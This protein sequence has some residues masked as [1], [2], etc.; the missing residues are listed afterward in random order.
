MQVMHGHRYRIRLCVLFLALITLLSST[1]TAQW[2]NETRFG[3]NKVNYEEFGWKIYETEHFHVYFYQGE[4]HIA[5]AAAQMAEDA[6]GRLSDELEYHISDTV[7]IL[8]Y[9]SHNDF[10]QTNATWGLIGE[11]TLGFTE[12]FKNRIVLPFNGSYAEFRHVIH[13][14][15]VHAF[16]FDMFYRREGGLSA[17]GRLWWSPPLWFAEG[18]AEYYSTDWTTEKNMWVRGAVIDGYLSLDGYQ[19]YTSGYALLRWIGE[20]YGHK[21]IAAIMRRMAITNDPGGSF[22]AELGT[23]LEDIQIRWERH[24]KRFYWPEIER[25]ELV[26]EIA[27]PLTHHR[28]ERHFFNYSPAIA[29]QGDRIAFLSDREEYTSIYIMSAI[30]G[31][32]IRKVLTGEQSGHFE[33]MQFLRATIS[34]SPNGESIAFT[35]KDHSLDALYIVRAEDGAIEHRFRWP[36][37]NSLHGPD[38]SSDSLYIAFVGVKQG[39]SD[40]YTVNIATGELRQLTDDMHDETGPEWSP[41][42]TQIAFASDQRANASHPPDSLSIPVGKGRSIYVVDVETGRV[43]AVTSAAGNDLSPTWSPDGRYIAFSSDRNGIYNLYVSDLQEGSTDTSGAVAPDTPDDT[44]IPLTDVLNGVFLPHW[45]LDGRKIVFA[46]FNYG[47]YDIYTLREPLERLGEV[48]PLQ[49]AEYVRREREEQDA[50]STRYLQ[51]PPLSGRGQWAFSLQPTDSSGTPLEFVAKPYELHFSP[52]LV[53]GI[54]LFDNIS[55]LTLQSLLMVSDQMGDHQ[56]LLYANIRR[57]VED[58]N[59]ELNYRYLK[60]RLNWGFD[61]YQYHQYYLRSLVSTS[62]T[63]DRIYGAGVVASYPFD[64]FTRLEGALGISGRERIAFSAGPFDTMRE[65]LPSVMTLSPS[66]TL[67]NDH[68]LWGITGPV[69]GSRSSVEIKHAPKIDFNTYAYTTTIADWRHYTRIGRDYTFSTRVSA[70]GS[71]GRNPARFL[72][73]GINYWINFHYAPRIDISSDNLLPITE[74]VGPLRGARYGEM[75]GSR[76]GVVNFEFRYPL[77]RHVAWGW[78]IPVTLRNIRGAVFLDMGTVWGNGRDFSPFASGSRYRLNTTDDPSYGPR[79]MGGVGFGWRLN[80]GYFVLKWDMAWPTDLKQ[81]IKGSRQ[82][83]S[84]GADF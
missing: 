4:R 66:L 80:L 25:R 11:G 33:E 45:S 39:K 1:A 58:A 36:E 73:G 79:S 67:V 42:G 69:N 81:T 17:A 2:W 49:S 50:D 30:D 22:R 14:E 82:Y 18:L 63:S 31:R 10:E 27:R 12:L 84:L 60:S 61:I 26:D 3:R 46:S 8:I 21:K 23:D 5:V 59:F 64:K 68:T 28:K 52:D 55:G 70:G 53:N 56:I 19:A 32:I 40:L 38:W 48:E 16:M 15:L 24:L 71:F 62:W 47:G 37:F 83:W 77:V 72:L 44:A 74:F 20:E 51:R 35:A 57:N 29:P 54:V 13:H 9:D 78:P 43:R 34:W 76:Y 41:D 65:R 7:P 6:Y 75:R